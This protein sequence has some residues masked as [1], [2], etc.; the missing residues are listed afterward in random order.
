MVVAA[1]GSALCR[2]A[3]SLETVQNAATEWVKV[4]TETARLETEWA[5]SRVLLE[6]TIDGLKERATQLE[7]KRDNVRSATAKDREEIDALRTKTRAAADD[8]QEAERRLK[9][10]DA[11]LIRLR[12]QLPPRLAD[13]LEM[14]Y[15]SLADPKLAASERMQVTTTILTRCAQFNGAVTSGQEVLSIDGAKKSFE[16]IY[17]GL[18]HGYALDRQAGKAWLGAPG[19]DGWKW[20]ARPAVAAAVKTLIAIYDD[21]ADPEFVTVPARL[22]HTAEATGGQ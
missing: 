22:A 20:T 21:K 12:G 14:S 6:S 18:S 13:A 5:S 9:A 1:A 19:A 15:R 2:A 16:T 8:L 10:V 4:R 17:W 7:D 3:E 11:R